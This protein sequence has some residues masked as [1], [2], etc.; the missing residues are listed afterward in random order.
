MP[1]DRPSMATIIERVTTDLESRGFGTETRVRR[2]VL[3]VLTRVIAG[4]AHGLYGFIAWVSRQFLPDTQDEENL[5]RYASQYGIVQAPATKAAGQVRVSGT[6]GVVIPLGL[7]LVRADG[8]E[9][10][11]T[12]EATIAAGFAALDIESVT[13]G[14]LGNADAGVVLSIASQVAGLSATAVVEAGAI[15]GGGDQETI[16]ALRARVLDFK[17]RRPHG[18]AAHDYEVWAKQVPGVTRAW[19]QPM[20][21]GIGTMGLFFV[22][23]G[24]ADPIPSPAEVAVVQAYIDE[25]RP[26]TVK[27]FTVYAPVPLDVPMSIRLRPDTTAGRAAVLAQLQDLFTREAQPGG[28]IPLTH[29]AEAISLAAGEYD[30]DLEEPLGDIVP[31]A[32][33][34]PRLGTVTWL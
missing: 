12:A 20:L 2:S 6:N 17:R 33:Y 29:V 21:N 7:R 32:G 3:Y 15:T 16:D 5:R 14:L 10:L 34:M 8:H 4:G 22:R 9:Y 26:V 24:D 31:A 1:F 11:T 28:T 25:L 19:P 18:G 23:D 13:A 27:D 30:H